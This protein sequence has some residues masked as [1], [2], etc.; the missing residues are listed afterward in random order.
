[1]RAFIV[2]V[3]LAVAPIIHAQ[4]TEAAISARLMNKPLYLRGFWSSESLHFNADGRLIGD[5]VP[6]PFTLSGFELKKVDLE[7][8][9][10]VLVG[11]RV[12][13]ALKKNQQKRVR[14][15]VGIRIDIEAPPTG[16]Y[17][18]A[19]DAIFVTGLA[20]LVPM[21]PD[22]WK[23]YATKNFLPD[24]SPRPQP[25]KLEPFKMD[26]SIKP[27]VLTNK[28]DP[29]YPAWVREIG[30]G[31]QNVINIWVTR[32]GNPSHYSI[33]SPIGMGLDEAALAAVMKYRFS[34]ATKDGKPVV[35]E[36]NIALSFDRFQ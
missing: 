29:K 14:L 17:S 13:L 27:P 23:D 16:D 10:L 21:L 28:V 12:G 33:I 20:E 6:V 30:Y 36:V 18:H 3:L 34:P 22:Y 8:D 9:K 25:E 19:L 32:E 15:P 4:S 2:S 35:V 31:G 26:K 5:S 7:P 11:H 1:M 24:A